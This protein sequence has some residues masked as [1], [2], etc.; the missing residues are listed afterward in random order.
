VLPQLLPQLRLLQ[1]LSPVLPVGSY[2]YSQGLEWA[3]EKQ[4]INNVS[5]LDVWLQNLIQGPLTHQELP[6]LRQLYEASCNTRVD[7]FDYWSQ[8]V[9]ASRDTA[10]LRAEERSR[11]KAYLRVL[12]ALPDQANP[13]Y[14]PGMQRTPLASMGWAASQ[15]NID[16]YSLLAAYAHNWL[17][18]YIINGVKIIPLG[19]SDGQ[20]LLHSLL[21][22]IEQAIQHSIEVAEADIG[23][24]TPAVAMASCGHENQYTRIYRS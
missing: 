22:K 23:F 16:L 19:Q 14:I 3:V 5:D 15:W 13:S 12:R 11:A 20:Q 1:L 24:S 6:L 18:T 21:P 7:D 4:W 10:E 2:S 17:E 9:L 8:I